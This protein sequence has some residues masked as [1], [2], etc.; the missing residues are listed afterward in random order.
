MVFIVVLRAKS[1]TARLVAAK[2]NFTLIEGT[3]FALGHFQNDPFWGA[4]IL[5]IP[6]IM[7]VTKAFFFG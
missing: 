2:Q 5:P 6:F 4:I 3:V 7:L 1:N